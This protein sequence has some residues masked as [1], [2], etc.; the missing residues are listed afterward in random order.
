MIAAV[1]GVVAAVVIV[2]GGWFAPAPD[3]LT[4]RVLRA[5]RGSRLLLWA[6]VPF[7]LALMLA[8]LLG[9]NGR[10]GPLLVTLLGLVGLAIL[11]VGW[12]A[13]SYPE[14]EA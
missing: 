5:A 10:S 13:W 3:L 7:V 2:V 12:F 9:A 14:V 1:L 4:G 8:A 11:L 6:A